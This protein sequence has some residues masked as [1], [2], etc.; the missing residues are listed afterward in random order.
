MYKCKSGVHKGVKYKTCSIGAALTYCIGQ[1]VSECVVANL[2]YEGCF[3]AEI[4]EHSQY[5]AGSA[6]GIYEYHGSC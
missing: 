2:A 4:I 6:A 5:I 1:H 3:S